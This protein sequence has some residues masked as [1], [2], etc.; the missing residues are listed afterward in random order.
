MK[1]TLLL[2]L[3][4]HL[5]VAAPAQSPPGFKWVKTITFSLATSNAEVFD[6]CTDPAGN[7]YVYGTFYG[8]LNFGGNVNLQ[9]QGA[10]EGYFLAKYAPNGVLGW[11]RKIVAPNGQL[12]YSPDQNPGGVS[13]DTLGNV[14]ISGQLSNIALD[15]GDGTVVQRS[16]QGAPLC[17]DL[18]IAK[19]DAA[20]Q[21][22]WVAQ[23]SGSAGTFQTATRLV[24]GK[25]G[26][27]F[28]AGSYGGQQLKLNG[29]PAYTNLE[30]DGLYMAH[31]S[32]SGQAVA[33]WF[34]D[35]GSGY[36]QVDHLAVTAQQVIATGLYDG[37]ALQFG[38]GVAL[39]AYGSSG[40]SNYFVAAYNTQGSAQWAYNLNSESYVEVLDVAADTSGRPYVVVDFRNSLYSNDAEIATTSAGN[41]AGILLHRTDSVFQPVVE[42]QYA[43]EA[44]PLANVAVD[45][46][47]RF[48]VAGGFSDPSLSVGNVLLQN[49][50][51]ACDDVLLIGG[52]NDGL[53]L[54]WVR[55][56]G[57]VGCEGIF[58]AYFGRAL[59]TDRAGDLYAVGA[60]HEVLDL[61]NFSKNGEGLFITK[62]GT[63]IVATVNPADDDRSFSVLPNPSRGDFSIRGADLAEPLHLT[64]YDAQGRICHQRLASRTTDLDFQLILPA[65]LYTLEWQSRR[66]IGQQKVLIVR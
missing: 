3:A 47:D 27:V 35:N 46:H 16:C 66:Q 64:L 55:S 49:Q 5:L 36:A 26:A 45:N 17:S 6:F 41:Y 44:Y 59:A 22:Q 19:F 7:S 34:F 40:A 56:A 10:V 43:G 4:C 15:F 24:V 39:E 31:F 21:V 52:K 57:G 11:V 9:A 1:Q 32:S 54:S 62:L 58:S 2:A 13:A 23:G 48:F 60:F 53:P 18:F 30:N 61:D 25:D 20:G 63:A 29:Q 14:Y 28:I 12:I 65:G 37:G 8:S 42:V 38:N 51:P 50:N 33:A